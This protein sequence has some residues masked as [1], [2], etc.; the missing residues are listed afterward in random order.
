M[1]LTVDGVLYLTFYCN[2]DG[3][4]HLVAGNYAQLFLCVGFLS[5]VTSAIVKSFEP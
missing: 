3:F 2:G 4:I 5:V 1:N